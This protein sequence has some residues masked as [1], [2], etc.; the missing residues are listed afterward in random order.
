M[1]RTYRE[2]NKRAT[3]NMIFENLHVARRNIVPFDTKH[4]KMNKKKNN[5]PHRQTPT[6]E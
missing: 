2:L 1:M 6:N 4:S 3:N 5:K